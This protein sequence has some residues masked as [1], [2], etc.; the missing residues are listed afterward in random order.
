MSGL[1]GRNRK[2]EC[3]CSGS[4]MDDGT[5]R[6]FG[7]RNTW[8]GT[9]SPTEFRIKVRLLRPYLTRVQVCFLQKISTQP[10]TFSVF[11]FFNSNSER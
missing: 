10:E 8:E 3:L 4:G 7:A 5:I 6:S 11:S 2:Y 1:P 9:G